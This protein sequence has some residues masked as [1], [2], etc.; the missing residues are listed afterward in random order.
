MLLTTK[1]QAVRRKCVA[2]LVMD[3]DAVVPTGRR[4]LH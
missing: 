1:N 2:T 3:P 4:Y